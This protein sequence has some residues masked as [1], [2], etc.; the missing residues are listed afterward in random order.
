MGVSTDVRSGVSIDVS[1]YAKRRRVAAVIVVRERC[2]AM[3]RHCMT[4]RHSRLS[5]ESIPM[6]AES[7]SVWRQELYGVVESGR[8]WFGGVDRGN[9]SRCA[10]KGSSV[11]D[12]PPAW[13]LCGATLCFLG[14]LSLSEMGSDVLAS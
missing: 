7:D 1:I 6:A 13:P 14:L 11:S 8:E 12:Q 2:C 4:T 10:S 3:S 5:W 9:A